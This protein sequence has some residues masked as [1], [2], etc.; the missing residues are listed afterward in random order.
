MSGFWVGLI[1]MAGAAVVFKAVKSLA[2]EA[3]AGLAGIGAV[4]MVSGAS[5]VG[6]RGT[7][8]VAFMAMV[9]AG[10]AFL[11]GAVKDDKEVFLGRLVG[12]GLLVLGIFAMAVLAGNPDASGFLEALALLWDAIKEGAYTLAKAWRLVT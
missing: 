2:A 9:V 5:N 12:I 1:I 3:V 11:F 6:E 10:W 7:Q 4:L 8:F